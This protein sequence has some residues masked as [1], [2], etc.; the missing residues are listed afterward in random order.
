MSTFKCSLSNACCRGSIGRVE[1]T[2]VSERAAVTRQWERE[3]AEPLT[4]DALVPA[5]PPHVRVLAEFLSLWSI[6]GSWKQLR[7]DRPLQVGPRTISCDVAM[8]LMI[9]L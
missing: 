3:T 5:A 9:D 6:S 2:R 4:H 8:T 7:R 1:E